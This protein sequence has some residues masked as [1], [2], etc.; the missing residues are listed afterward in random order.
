MTT[1]NIPPRLANTMLAVVIK[2]YKMEFKD[3]LLDH[4]YYA[5]DNNYYSN[6]AGQKWNTFQDFYDEYHDA[7][8]DM[9]LIYRWDIKKDDEENLCMK[10]FIIHQRKGIY[11]P[12]F[13]ESVSESDFENIQKLLQPH[14]DKLA[15]IWLPFSVS[16]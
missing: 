2:I 8:I 7:D 4:D 16:K 15:R 1:D 13:I 3:L 6:D 5:S 9:N 11:A 14:L 10:I 12:H